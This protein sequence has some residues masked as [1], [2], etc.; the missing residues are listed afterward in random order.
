MEVTKKSTRDWQAERSRRLFAGGLVLLAVLALAFLLMPA[1]HERPRDDDGQL[2]GSRP[3]SA[4]AASEVPKFGARATKDVARR[5][6]VVL[7]RAA[8]TIEVLTEVDRMPAAGVPVRVMRFFRGRQGIQRYHTNSLGRVDLDDLT[9]GR[10]VVDAW[11]F[12]R[13]VAELIGGQRSV[14]RLSIP[15]GASVVGR[16]VDHEGKGCPGAEVWLSDTADSFSQGVRLVAADA[17]GRFT[18][19]HVPYGRWLSAFVPGYLPTECKQ[20]VRTGQ[21]L[22]I[23]LTAD[24]PG[25]VLTGEV[26]DSAG[27]AVEAATVVCG[28]VA[29]RSAIPSGVP[30]FEARTDSRGNFRVVGLPLQLR[31]PLWVDHPDYAVSGS[32]VK[33]EREQQRVRVTLTRGGSVHIVVV[34][35]GGNPISDARVGFLPRSGGAKAAL[36]LGPAWSRRSG[37]SDTD[38]VVGFRH[39]P[40]GE[41]R[42]SVFREGES[43][44]RDITIVEGRSTRVECRLNVASAGRV[45]HG[46]ILDADR[47]PVAK[48]RVW[49]VRDPTFT[50]GGRIERGE[51]RVGGVEHGRYVVHVFLDDTSW[52]GPVY[53]GN[54]ELGL[55]GPLEINLAVSQRTDGAIRGRVVGLPGPSQANVRLGLRRGQT[56]KVFQLRPDAEGQFEIVRLPAGEY[57]GWLSAGDGYGRTLSSLRVSAT[58]VSDIGVLDLNRVSDLLLD[59]RSSSGAKLDETLE[60]SD[61]GRRLTRAVRI[62]DG[63]GVVP[64]VSPGDYLLEYSGSAWAAAT[65]RIS[66]ADSESRQVRKRLVFTEGTPLVLSFHGVSDPG[67]VSAVVKRE[68][69]V[70][71]R[72]SQR[73][74]NGVC[75]LIVGL[76]DGLYQVT[77]THSGKS[78]S[79]QV[80]IQSS[81]R[82]RQKVELKFD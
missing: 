37:K 74:S 46:R 21:P 52:D 77:A 36:S 24:R 66:I 35:R 17:V 11:V 16:V 42:V 9:P 13:E 71:C 67:I 59:V 22:R 57:S 8:L 20:V 78:I 41:G 15:A 72:R 61:V 81:V 33:C 29:L 39:L 58:G 76:A 32:F 63:V 28:F 45:V 55:S 23:V 30:L 40:V 65:W 48:G 3:D 31:M 18:V 14:V 10:A 27:E 62:E 64:G 47:L 25:G 54:H 53:S 69:S 79:E 12:V 19:H 80:R 49:L 56:H 50:K 5:S 4:T 2:T 44:V 82:G 51:F 73:S 34:D 6:E 26:V 60:F 38:G 43:C 70:V 7:A 75:E 1:L 68:G